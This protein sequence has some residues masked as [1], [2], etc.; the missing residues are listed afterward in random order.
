MRDS[1][2]RK[3]ILSLLDCESKSAQDI[4]DNIGTPLET[5]EA[6]L[7][8]L[9]SENIC[10][11]VSDDEVSQWAVNKD[12]ETFAE[13]VEEFLSNKE[14]RN[15]QKS[16]FITSKHYH[17]RLDY[18]LVEYVLGRFHLQLAYQTE[19]DKKALGRI[20]LAS[21]SA[22]FFALHSNTTIFEELQ[23][24]QNQLDSSDA[25]RD[26]FFG[27][28]RSQFQTPLLEMLIADMKVLDY[29]SLYA[30]L[31]L[32]IAKVSIHVSLA[33]P[34]EK[35]VE[36]L[37]GGSFSLHRMMEEVRAG[38]LVSVADPMTFF[39]QGLALL[40]LGDYQTAIEDFDKALNGV[41]DSIQKAL[42]L[43]NKGWAFLNLKQYQKAIQCFEAGIAFD[44]EGEIPI[45]RENKQ[46]AEE[47]LARATDAD[48]LTQP[49]QNCFR[50][51]T[52]HSF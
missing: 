16:Q 1:L 21:P 8:R 43:N 29:G 5:V 3:I 45:L 4:A 40:H 33:T 6:Q 28:R 51:G 44:S 24:S 17:T 30:Q 36:A 2:C 13:L 9:A 31:Q 32:L 23:T 7:T 18:D 41:Q 25:T 20:L 12:I 22:L 35:Y 52:A 34:T 15:E 47:Y 48:N 37:G 38:Q 11:V 50:T 10:E 26:W 27:L 42:V 19:G 39:Y 46:V 14:E 49:T